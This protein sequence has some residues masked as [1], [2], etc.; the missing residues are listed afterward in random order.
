[1]HS[2]DFALFQSLLH[3]MNGIF[4]ITFFIYIHTIP[5]S[6]PNPYCINRRKRF[7]KKIVKNNNKNEKEIE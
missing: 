3:N 6:Q 7:K 4:V 2:S 5:T 1:M